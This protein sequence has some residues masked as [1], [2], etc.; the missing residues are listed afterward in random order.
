MRR[1]ALLSSNKAE[2]QSPSGR[3]LDSDGR[4]LLKHRIRVDAAWIVVLYC[5][6]NTISVLFPEGNGGGVVGCRLK[7]YLLDAIRG[8]S[9][10]R[11]AKHH[12][13]D[14]V[15]TVGFEDVYGDDVAQMAGAGGKDESSSL[16]PRLGYQAVCS[17]KAEVPAEVAPR[18]GD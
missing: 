18:V 8:E 17:W 3:K 10:L 16:I 4:D 2:E 7:P 11:F 6:L 14:A 5:S 1:S 9:S 12:G 15:T 13:A